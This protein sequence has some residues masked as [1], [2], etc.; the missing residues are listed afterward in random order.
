MWL[1]AHATRCQLRAAISHRVCPVIVVIYIAV[2]NEGK[3]A[4]TN[5]SGPRARAL[6]EVSWS[7]SSTS[8]WRCR[9]AGAVQR[10]SRACCAISST[11]RWPQRRGWCP[12][13]RGGPR[14]QSRRSSWSSCR[15]WCLCRARARP[16]RSQGACVHLAKRLMQLVTTPQISSVC[17]SGGTMSG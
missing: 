13:G 2:L 6:T 7:R 17:P 1:P 3:K 11:R 9:S 16:W 12:C 15:R 5:L 4:L 14:W 8:A 10:C